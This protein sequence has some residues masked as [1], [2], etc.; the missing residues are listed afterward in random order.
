[1]IG[2]DRAQ[3]A[4]DAM[5]PDAEPDCYC[6][7]WQCEAC[8]TQY[9]EPGTCTDPGCLAERESP[10]TLAELDDDYLMHGYPLAA[11]S[12]CP[13]HTHQCRTRDCCGED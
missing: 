11:K 12:D 8:E 2:L 10:A 7:R 5:E 6:D 13:A 4:Y 3:A 9:S 1:V